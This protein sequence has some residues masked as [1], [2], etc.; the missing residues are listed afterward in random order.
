MKRLFIRLNGRAN[1]WPV[2][3]GNSHPFYSPDDPDGLGNASYSII[4]TKSADLNLQQI[5]CELLVDAG[6]NT[7]SY[8]IR[9]ENRIPEA[10]ILTHPHLDHTVGIDWIAESFSHRHEFRK[11]YPLYATLPCWEFV[12]Q[13]FPQL[14]KI[15]EF[16]ELIP[17][18]QCK[19]DEVND[20]YVTAFPVFHGDSGFGASLL[21]LEYRNQDKN[22]VRAVFTG[23]ML[24]PLLRDRDFR[25]IAQARVMYIDCNNRFSYPESN[26]GSVTTI[27]PK[28]GAKSKYLGSW[29]EELSFSKLA[30]PHL[31][32]P[33][34]SEIHNYFSGFLKDNK[35]IKKIPFSV[36]EFLKKAEIPH[37]RLIHYSGYEDEKCYNEKVL[38]D[39]EL[40]SWASQIITREGL[41]SRIS[42]PR[43]GDIFRLV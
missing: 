21:L 8:I 16:H 32:Q 12:R 13:S 25:E 2:F 11:K 1:A 15:I 14:K 38:D 35:D 20:I 23:D 18:I 17:G 10:L 24:C 4:G 43:T 28:T 39:K 31:Q 22:A 9:H 37:T 34:N 33:F 6:N 27:D 5:E 36:S 26:H 30:A 19:I 3:L 7:A 40:E 42:V 29:L 41:N